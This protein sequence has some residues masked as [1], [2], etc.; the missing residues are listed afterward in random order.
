MAIGKEGRSLK[1]ENVYVI[2]IIRYHH[3]TFP[4]VTEIQLLPAMFKST[5]FSLLECIINCFNIC[6]FDE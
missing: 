1:K 4:K 5:Y 2:Y 3:I 6:Q